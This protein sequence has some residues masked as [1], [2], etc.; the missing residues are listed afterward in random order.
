[1]KILFQCRIGENISVAAPAATID[2]QRPTLCPAG[3]EKREI[4]SAAVVLVSLAGDCP[5]FR[6][7]INFFP[8]GKAYFLAMQRQIRQNIEAVFYGMAGTAIPLGYAVTILR[9]SPDR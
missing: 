5:A 4:Q 1:M 7:E 9:L 8:L 3:H 6:V 2:V